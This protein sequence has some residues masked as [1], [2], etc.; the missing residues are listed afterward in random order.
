MRIR[1]IAEL[2]K[3]VSIIA[4]VMAWP[5]SAYARD[6]DH[7]VLGAGVAAVPA[8]EG[9]DD[10]RAIPLP[11]IDIKEGWLFA[12]L[13]NGVGVAP[14]D[15]EHFTIG[16]SAVYMQGY[17]RRDVPRGVDKLS[18]GV[19]ARAFANIKA[20][21]FITTLGVVQ[22]ISGQTEGLVADVSISY[23]ILTTSRFTVTPMAGT[24]WANAKYND[25]YFG[26]SATEAAASGLSRFSAGSGFKDV[27]GTL[28]ASYR[29]TDRLTANVTGGVTSL[30]G[31]AQDSPLVDR[32]TQPI[33]FFSLT[34]RL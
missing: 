24:T 22:G 5:V 10:Y 20:G 21:G 32:K 28:T 30:L 9:S 7:I 25:R 34:Y 31:D 1:F 4:V 11:A 14:I 33:G 27:T 3:Q 6:E 29:L 16:V 18:D 15:T 26:I 12:N 8:V 17:R 19:G 23:P 2:L 13:P